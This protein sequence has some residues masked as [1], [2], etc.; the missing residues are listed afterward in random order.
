M[1]NEKNTSQS[2]AVGKAAGLKKRTEESLEAII[3]QASSSEPVL[4]DKNVTKYF[5]LRSETIKAVR[6]DHEDIKDLTKH[7]RKYGLYYLAAGD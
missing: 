1:E 7:G 5:A 2:K 3:A 6:A 4:S